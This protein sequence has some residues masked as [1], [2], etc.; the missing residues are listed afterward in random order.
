MWQV[1]KL[2]KVALS[3]ALKAKATRDLERLRRTFPANSIEFTKECVQNLL[4][5]VVVSIMIRTK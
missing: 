2:I 1:G 4:L 5:T 3:A